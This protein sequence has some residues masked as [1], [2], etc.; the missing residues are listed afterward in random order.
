MV[1]VVVIAPTPFLGTSSTRPL[2]QNF[3]PWAQ[4]SLTF[5][6][7]EG[8]REESTFERTWRSENG[9]ENYF[10]VLART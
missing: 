1:N 10:T 2:P 9:T 5:H 3:G 7:Y 6:H 8:M 4:T